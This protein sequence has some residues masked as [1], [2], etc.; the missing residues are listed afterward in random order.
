MFQR[1]QVLPLVLIIC[2]ALAAQ[3]TT[4]AAFRVLREK[5]QPQ[6]GSS[7]S[8]T[9]SMPG[10][11]G[12]TFDPN[13]PGGRC[14]RPW[15]SS[16]MH[17]SYWLFFYSFFHWFNVS[18]CTLVWS[19]DWREDIQT[20]SQILFPFCAAVLL[21]LHV[22]QCKFVNMIPCTSSVEGCCSYRR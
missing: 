2:L 8:L 6:R 9:S 22:K 13:N 12:C 10:A 16:D 1:N 3:A 4:I 5:S 19:S 18:F 11:S 15:E 20:S 17:C 7:V 21:S 14:P